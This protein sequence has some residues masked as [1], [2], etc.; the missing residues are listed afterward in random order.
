MW[1]N[2][3][4]IFRVLKFSGIKEK[5]VASALEISQWELKE[6][7]YG[8]KPANLNQAKKLLDLFGIYNICWAMKNNWK[9]M[10]YAI[11]SVLA[12]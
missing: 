7:L 9:W 4:R 8:Q 5:E 6:I 12:N 10:P 2:R 1:L 3:K 11:Q